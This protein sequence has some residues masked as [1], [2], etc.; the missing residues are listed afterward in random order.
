MIVKQERPISCVSCNRPTKY[1]TI[2]IIIIIIINI[3]I[4][5]IIVVYYSDHMGQ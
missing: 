5:I 2:R 3:S 1:N 4:S